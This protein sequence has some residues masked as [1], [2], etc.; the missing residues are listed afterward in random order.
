MRVNL[1]AGAHQDAGDVVVASGFFRSLDEAHAQLIERQF[2][3]KQK[4]D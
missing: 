3:A 4:L 2:G 1:L